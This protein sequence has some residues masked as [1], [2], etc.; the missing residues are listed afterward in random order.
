MLYQYSETVSSTH[1][2][3]HLRFKMHETKSTRSL[4]KESINDI[5]T[6]YNG[7]P[8]YVHQMS[9]YYQ[10]LLCY[11]SRWVIKTTFNFE[12][13]FFIKINREHIIADLL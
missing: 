7:R 2:E 6:S 12:G 3:K 4:Q 11:R 9:N 1:L 10:L 5:L 13:E 8:I